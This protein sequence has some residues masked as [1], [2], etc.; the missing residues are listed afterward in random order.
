MASILQG[1][2][3]GEFTSPKTVLGFYAG[4]LVIVEA[5]VGGACLILATDKDLHYLIPWVLGFGGIALIGVMAV[6]IAMNFRDPTKLQ[7]GR[8]T[9][10]EFL[11]YQRVTKGDSI[12]GE[13]IDKVPA[14]AAAL[15]NPSPSGPAADVNDTAPE[16][17]ERDAPSSET[18]GGRG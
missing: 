14:P 11:A 3:K 6:V 18:E 15:I 7:L 2:R 8:V 16:V 9:G 12:A 5:G 10:R 1:A 4:V 13:Y 17:S